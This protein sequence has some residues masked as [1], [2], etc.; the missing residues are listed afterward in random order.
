[1][2]DKIIAIDNYVDAEIVHLASKPTTL[3]TRSFDTTKATDVLGFQASTN[4][5]E[6]IR[7]T[8]SW[9]RQTAPDLTKRGALN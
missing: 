5:E 7:K 3:T 4:L 2:L 8:I 9:Y 1:M 6:G